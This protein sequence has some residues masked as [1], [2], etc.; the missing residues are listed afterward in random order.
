MRN[1]HFFEHLVL[2]DLMNDLIDNLLEILIFT[3]RNFTKNG[4][5]FLLFKYSCSLYTI[6]GGNKTVGG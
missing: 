1:G 6:L 2:I 3:L 5:V 4:D